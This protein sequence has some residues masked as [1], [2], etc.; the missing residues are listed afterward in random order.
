MPRSKLRA[1]WPIF[2]L[3]VAFLGAAVGMA[4][5]G[6]E[7]ETPTPKPVKKKTYH[8]A[9]PAQKLF[10][11]ATALVEEGKREQAVKGFEGLIALYPDSPYA[12]KARN[13]LAILGATEKPAPEPTP[14]PRCQ[15][16]GQTVNLEGAWSFVFKLQDTSP[17]EYN[18]REYPLVTR[19]YDG[20]QRFSLE[21]N[22]CLVKLTPESGETVEGVISPRDGGYSVTFNLPS[23]PCW[24]DSGRFSEECGRGNVAIFILQS[25]SLMRTTQSWPNPFMRLGCGYT[26]TLAK[27]FKAAQNLEKK[28]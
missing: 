16:E 8:A 15:C 28:E 13:Y 6:V 27:A 17:G 7:P 12:A 23:L 10:E 18:G 21:Q 2:I 14:D 24:K 11:K 26:A 25:S 1:V 4:V 19:M 9:D 20:K 22:G 3:F 5:A